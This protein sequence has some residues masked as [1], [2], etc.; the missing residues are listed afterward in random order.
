M[1][2][3]AFDMYGTLC[4]PQA[5]T[6]R[7]GSFVAE[8]EP[9]AQVWRRK[10]LEYSF[11]VSMMGRYENFW[12]LTRRAL[13]YALESAGITLNETAIEHIMDAYRHLELFPDTKEGLRQLHDA[14]FRMIVLSNG[15]P[16]MLHDL[17]DNT[18]L[19]PYFEEI[20][21]AD[22][23]KV[24]KPDPR[25]YQLAAEYF[26]CPIADVWMISSNSFDAVGAKAAGMQV[27]WVNRRDEVLDKV[28]GRPDI[29]TS[30]LVTLAQELK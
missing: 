30:N 19:A 29:V 18:G 17:V 24:F 26:K 10:Q 14:G 22:A 20:V 4:D 27:A 15:S 1:R 8:A 5:V 3:L 9:I 7:L 25:V 28:G 6:Q 12:R 13:D 16:D 2:F 11:M 21:S 23:V